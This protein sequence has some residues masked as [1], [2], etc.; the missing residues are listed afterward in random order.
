MTI[1]DGD[2]QFQVFYCL[3]DGPPVRFV[4]CSLENIE[5]ASREARQIGTVN[6]EVSGHMSPSTRH[7]YQRLGEVS[8][9]GVEAA[10]VLDHYDGLIQTSN[11]EFIEHLR[12]GP[13]S[14]V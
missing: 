2:P 1:P 8:G 13:P 14:Q 6:S 7:F 5:T 4:A 10:A 12:N 3:H 9:R 11:E